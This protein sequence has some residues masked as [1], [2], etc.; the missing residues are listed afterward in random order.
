[1]PTSLNTMVLADEHFSRGNTL[2]AMSLPQGSLVIMIKRGDRYIVPN[3]TM[4]LHPGD[5]LLLMQESPASVP[6]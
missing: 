1:M 5:T 6:D 3:G 2:G 4:P